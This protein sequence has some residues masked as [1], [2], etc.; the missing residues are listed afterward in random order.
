METDDENILRDLH[1]MRSLGTVLVSMTDKL[2]GK[3]IAKAQRET[4]APTVKSS[5]VEPEPSAP[6]PTAGDDAVIDFAADDSPFEAEPNAE[7]RTRAKPVAPTAKRG[8]GR[9]PKSAVRVQMMK[10]P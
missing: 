8:P 2:I 10:A 5:G 4:P 6:Q 7:A 1:E 3:F 9:P